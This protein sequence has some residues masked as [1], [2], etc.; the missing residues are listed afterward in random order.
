M[1]KDTRYG[2]DAYRIRHGVGE[3]I[4]GGIKRKRKNSGENENENEID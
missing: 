2:E 1:E 4:K 3:I